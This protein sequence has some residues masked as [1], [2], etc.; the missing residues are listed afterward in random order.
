MNPLRYF[1]VAGLIG[2]MLFLLVGGVSW[3][4]NP[5]KEE[6]AEIDMIV[7]QICSEA[8]ADIWGAG[9]CKRAVTPAVISWR[10]NVR[11]C[12]SGGI[13][14]VCILT[15]RGLRI[16]HTGGLLIYSEEIAFNDHVRQRVRDQIVWIGEPLNLP[17]LKS[18]TP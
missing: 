5:D 15:E 6:Q 10:E 1:W 12:V 2:W 17:P 11:P 16:Q 7:E 8:Y 13:P 9:N 14:A 3:I 18:D 4:F